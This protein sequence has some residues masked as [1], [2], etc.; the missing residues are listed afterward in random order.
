MDERRREFFQSRHQL[1]KML[2]HQLAERVA[3]G[4][5]LD[6]YFQ[7]PL[8]LGEVHQALFH[9]GLLEHAHQLHQL[10][11]L[12]ARP[13]ARGQRDFPGRQHLRDVSLVATDRH[14][15]LGSRFR[16]PGR[17][18]FA[19]GGFRGRFRRGLRARGF[20]AF[21]PFA[22]QL[23]GLLEHRRVLR[24]PFQ[25]ADI[26]HD[27][28]FTRGRQLG[29]H[30][31]HARDFL[32]RDARFRCFHRGCRGF[33]SWRACRPASGCLGGRSAGLFARLRCLGFLFLA[34]RRHRHRQCHQS[35]RQISLVHVGLCSG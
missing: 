16:R 3:R 24:R 34:G 35:C 21:F 1:V 26:H 28:R 30:S 27:Q 4:V 7:Q 23:L 33:R 2:R 32:R 31:N 6:R 9:R 19:L 25:L 20:A 22:E 10:Q 13:R 14:R 11:R 8:L 18:G 12:L 17:R 15:G 29:R 5:F